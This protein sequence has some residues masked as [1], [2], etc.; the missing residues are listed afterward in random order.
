MAKQK[1]KC[2]KGAARRGKQS[3]LV[4]HKNGGDASMEDRV[5]C[6]AASGLVNLGN[7]CFFNAVVQVEFALLSIWPVSLNCGGRDHPPRCS[8]PR[9][10][11]PRLL[12]FMKL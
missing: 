5:A 10:G 9:R 12:L 6:P 3:E 11:C 4:K 2:V 7:T 1:Q 8:P